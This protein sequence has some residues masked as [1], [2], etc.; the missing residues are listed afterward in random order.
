M[1]RILDLAPANAA[2]ATRLLAEAGHDVIRVEC[3][4]GDALR[5]QG[6]FV[7]GAPVLESGANHLFL[8]AGKRSVSLDLE[9]DAGKDILLEL[10]RGC[11]VMIA[12]DSCPVAEADLFAAQ[13]DLVFID[14][15]SEMGE[16]CTVAR[17]G[18]LSITGQ[19][20]ERPYV[21]GGHVAFAITGLHVALAASAALLAGEDNAGGHRIT[22][23]ETECLIS[24]MEQA[25]VGY[26]AL[27][28][29]AERMGY[30]GAVTAVSGAF[31]CADGYW[32]LSVPPSGDGWKRFVEWTGDPA[33]NSDK[34]LESEAH[35]NAQKEKLLDEIDR[36]SMGFAKLDLVT[37]GQERRIPAT[38][39]ATPMELLDDPQ[40]VA[41][42]YLRGMSHP[43][44]GQVRLPVGAIAVAKGDAIARAPMLGEHTAEILAE[45]G[46][47]DAQRS[48]LIEMAV[49]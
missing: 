2:Y 31:P 29:V 35:R 24:M 47:S 9:S 6:P 4:R 26:T 8:N 28:K 15:T 48:A 45:L 40:L 39:V 25:M 33:F 21:P 43:L 3:P 23:S 36:W 19:P 11:D 37:Q 41:R 17:S 20:G 13:P 1:A 49:I 18:L 7:D 38:P 22:V 32:M 12:S 42:G 14:V 27:G 46:Y 5:R 16:L 30:R 34:D 44:L 10:V